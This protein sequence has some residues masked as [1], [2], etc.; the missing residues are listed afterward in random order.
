MGMKRQPPSGF[1]PIK[2]TLDPRRADAAFPMQ[3][4][5]VVLLVQMQNY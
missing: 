1:D 2:E 5:G 3:A 4:N